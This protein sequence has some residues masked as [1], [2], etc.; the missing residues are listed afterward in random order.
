M[1][2]FID[3]PKSNFQPMKGLIQKLGIFLDLLH[4]PFQSW[5]IFVV[6]VFWQL[7]SKLMSDVNI[8]HDRI[9]SVDLWGWKQLLCKPSQNYYSNL[10]VG[11]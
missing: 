9:L 5:S 8:S 3:L 7:K 10:S 2:G 11:P 6:L 4:T 1:N